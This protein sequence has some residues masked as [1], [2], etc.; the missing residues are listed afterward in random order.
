MRRNLVVLV[1]LL[2]A[3]PASAQ[4]T[5][6][7]ELYGDDGDIVF[8]DLYTIDSAGRLA[9]GASTNDAAAFSTESVYRYDARGELVE[10]RI[11]VLEGPS[12]DDLGWA[13]P[14]RVTTART[15]DTV[16]VRRAGARPELTSVEVWSF[17]ARGLPTRVEITPSSVG[18]GERDEYHCAFDLAGRP[19][20][21]GRTTGPSRRVERRWIWSGDTL[22]GV[23]RTWISGEQQGAS[24]STLR[25]RGG[26][27]EIVERGGRVAE[28][29]TGSCDQ[30]LFEHCS[31][32][33]GPLPAG[34]ARATLP[35][36]RGER[37]QRPRGRGGLAFPEAV[38]RAPLTLASL[39]AAYPSR[40]VWTAVGFY[41]NSPDTPYP[42]VCIGPEG[43]ACL[44][45]IEHDDRRRART[46]STRDPTLVG[47]AGIGVG[48]R[49]PRIAARLERCEL[50]RGLVEGIACRVRELP[51]VEV[52]L[53][54]GDYLATADEHVPPSEEV[55][56]ARRVVRLE[57][58]SR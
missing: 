30:I 25:R 28:R 16:T 45:A 2:C 35:A 19:V 17:D 10:E 55:L 42:F 15:E 13:P 21:L 43:G 41:E 6:R 56:A 14:T 22:T 29:W 23:E 7:Y 33:F 51:S 9:A 5:C 12:G 27:I 24:V 48:A 47:P 44:T 18:G 38:L 58:A 34:G 11:N 37:I 52:W 36:T 53:D 40:A 49:Y 31:P 1:A 8:D 3:A 20:Y 4:E 46:V 54:E 39:R 32:I 50:R 57:W 26:S